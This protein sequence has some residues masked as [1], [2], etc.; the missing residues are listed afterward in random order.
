MAVW[1]RFPRATPGAYPSSTGGALNAVAASPEERIREAS[2]LRRVMSADDAAQLIGTEAVVGVSGFARA[3]SPKEVPLAL[4]RQARSGRALRLTV[5]TGAS[6]GGEIDQAMAAAGAL[7]RRLPYQ[8]LPEMR[9]YIN[10]GR[11]AYDDPHLGVFPEL[12]RAGHLGPMDVAIIEACRVTD[13]GGLVLTSSVGNSP[14]YA[15]VAA[16]VIVELNRWHPP[17]MLGMHDIWIDE[18]PPGRQPL[19]LT[20]PLERIGSPVVRF[21]PKRLAA[22]VLTDRPDHPYTFRPPDEVSVRIGGHLMDFLEG[23]VRAG[24]LPPGLL[25]LQMGIGSIGDAVLGSL[26]GWGRTGLTFFSE[27]IQDGMLDLIEA[28][29][30]RG[31]SG[32]S[33]ALSAA[34][35]A[36]LYRDLPRFRH[37]LVLRPQ[38]IS[39]GGEAIRRLGVIAINTAVEVDLYGQVNSTHLA[40]TAM[41]NGIGGSGDYSR[42]AHLPIFVTPSVVRDGRVSCIVPMVS[43]VDHTE[44]DV[45]VI[46]TEQGV[47]D[48]RGLSPRERAPRLIAVAHP[49]YRPLL[50]DYFRRASARGGHTPHLLD[51]AFSWHLRAAATGTMRPAAPGNNP[52]AEGSAQS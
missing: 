49:T 12:V 38:E 33:L 26:A 29:V 35:Q 5:W 14:L 19:P 18:E 23:E 47:A 11:I 28:G 52:Q 15:K 51:E 7:A 43:H 25:P 4:A 41:I 37:Y 50:E 36:R 9:P 22:V 17:E 39:N 27:V 30:V 31:A 48:L 10:A 40:G 3:G 46:V 8:S 45:A 13:D 20:D 44:H 21:D 1:R 6:P 16:R 24:R 42:H 2:F 32:T 34:G